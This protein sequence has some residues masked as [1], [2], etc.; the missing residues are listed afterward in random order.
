VNGACSLIGNEEIAQ[1]KRIRHGLAC[2]KA[3]DQQGSQ[4]GLKK[5]SRSAHTN[6]SSEELL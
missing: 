2:R 1:G 5:G 6:I 4:D 3:E